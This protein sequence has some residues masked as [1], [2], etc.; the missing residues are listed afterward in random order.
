MP[1]SGYHDLYSGHASRS[2]AEA[3]LD[4]QQTAGKLYSEGSSVDDIAAWS[5]NPIYEFLFESPPADTSTSVQ[6]GMSRSTN[7]LA[8]GSTAAAVAP[9]NLLCFSQAHHAIV[10]TMTPDGFVESV[11][12]VVEL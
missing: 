8:L 6:V 1:A 12:A 2:V 10:L 9:A 11:S 3:Y 5:Q 7:S 4:Y